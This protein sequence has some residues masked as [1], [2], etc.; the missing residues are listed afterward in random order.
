MGLIL[1]HDSG[2]DTLMRGTIAPFGAEIPG[3]K[4]T[5]YEGAKDPGGC[6]FRV[7]FSYI[8]CILALTS[9]GPGLDQDWSPGGR[10]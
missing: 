6:G 2:L 3:G 7:D 10:W 5:E 8:F 4:K 9:P 1:A